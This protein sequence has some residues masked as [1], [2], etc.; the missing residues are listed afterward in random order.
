MTEFLLPRNCPPCPDG[1]PDW[2]V[3]IR[4]EWIET[5]QVSIDAI[6]DNLEIGL[7]LVGP[8]SEYYKVATD[9]VGI[10]HILTDETRGWYIKTANWGCW[11]TPKPSI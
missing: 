2:I 11:S 9:T 7:C 3:K 6:R 5:S 1:T 4:A 10:R 8:D